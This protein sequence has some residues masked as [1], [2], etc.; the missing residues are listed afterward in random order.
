MD[1]SGIVWGYHRRE[2]RELARN[3]RRGMT[4]AEKRLWQCLRSSRLDGFHFRRQQVIDGF[5]ADFYCHGAGLVVELDGPIHE[6]RADYDAER[7]RIL[8]SRGL[9]VMRIANH[10][11]IQELDAVR[12]EILRVAR[13]LASD[14]RPP[15]TP[16][17]GEAGVP[18]PE[19]MPSTAA[20]VSPSPAGRRLGGTPAGE[21]P[22]ASAQPVAVASAVDSPSPVGR[23]LGGRS[24]ELVRTPEE[25]D[26]LFPWLRQDLIRGIP[27]YITPAWTEDRSHFDAEHYAACWE[28]IGFSSVTLLTG[29]HDGYLMFPSR[30]S[31]QQPERDFFGEQVAACRRRG[32]RVMAYYSLTLDS[33]VGSEH[34]EWRVRDLEGRV[35]VPSYEGFSHYHWLCLNSPYRD[36][37]V[38]Q[39]E[40]VVD[41]YEV[42]GVWIDI[43]YLPAHP[44][45][46]NRDTCF[47]D[48]CHRQYSEWYRGQHL[49]DAAGTP[50]HNEFRADTYRNF[51]VQLKTMLL[52]KAR[53]LA[54]TFNGAGR[55]RMPRYQRC[56]ELADFL[57]GEAH[58][59]ISLSVTSKSHRNDGRPFELLS[60]AEIC[61]SH[62]QLKP[63][64]LIKLE[65]LSTLLAGGTYTMGITHAPDGRL[66]PANVDRLVA[67]G[68]WIRERRDLFADARPVYEMGI[69]ASDGG[70][71]GCEAW[72]ELLRKG[73]FLFN[74]FMDLPALELLREYRLI[75]VPM[76]R[77]ITPAELAALA[78]YAECGGNVLIEY[79]REALRAGDAGLQELIGA[80]AVREDSAYAFYLAPHDP[81]LAM[82]IPAD[83]PVLIQCGVACVVSLTTATT[84]ADLVPQFR[85][86]V[87]SSDIQ[88]V[89][90][91]WARPDEAAYH[92]GITVHRPGQGC[93]MFTALP[94]TGR[95][96]EAHRCPWPETL[97]Q[98]CVRSL[99]ET[100]QVSVG[101]YNR[102]EVN[103][104]EQPQRLL[105]HFV[106]HD[107]G[108]GADM[109]GRGEQ[110]FVRDLPVSLAE[111]L[112]VRVAGATLEPEGTPLALTATGV[113][114]PSLGVDQAVGL[115]LATQ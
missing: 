58:N 64:T 66:S 8:G 112:R 85:D 101:A 80:A 77:R 86:K 84:V 104:C 35:Y 22:M 96:T 87:R 62:N 38:A 57:S 44:A 10:R 88:T 37:V 12:Q 24:A 65:S 113:V 56:D 46:V 30:F 73:H 82:D 111:G 27:H 72:A 9:V 54:L 103:L 76:G 71:T 47:C 17:S 41:N 67:W 2:K 23:G 106:N 83:E 48:W 29:H 114:L 102:V 31:R 21:P 5:V 15:E 90:N 70:P 105:L 94:L 13:S 28:R 97:A 89:P 79:P 115:E 32:M 95:N 6:R 93:V 43:L 63:D 11:V 61:W 1:R 68:E 81:G 40:E 14:A 3:L 42:D 92:P 60:C 52:S 18:A 45:D 34:P 49:L 100:Q 39:L 19:L 78:S 51:L 26:R 7:D 75:V 69:L 20:A 99:L 110:Q 16:G 98:N 74:V 36:H 91:Y 107:Y 33:L 25:V 4:L 55:R 50:R 53:P 109:H 108:P 59:P